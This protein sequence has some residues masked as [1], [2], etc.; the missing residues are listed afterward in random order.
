MTTSRFNL[1]KAAIKAYP[2]SSYI[3]RVIT[4]RLRIKYI[5]ALQLMGTSYILHP[6]NNVERKQPC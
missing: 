1:Y 3:E 4:Q 6:D 2:Y 5:K